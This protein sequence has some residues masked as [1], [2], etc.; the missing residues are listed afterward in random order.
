MTQAEPLPFTEEEWAQTPAA[1]QEFVHPLIIPVQAL[2]TEVQSLREQLN[3]NS[4]KSSMPPS[5]DGPRV[6]PKQKS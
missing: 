4:R 6:P 3:R 5:S 2:E 1:V